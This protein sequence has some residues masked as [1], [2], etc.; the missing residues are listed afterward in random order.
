MITPKDELTA[1]LTLSKIEKIRPA[2]AKFLYQSVGNALDIFRL[3]KDLVNIVPGVSQ[4]LIEALDDSESLCEAEKE[5]CFIDKNAIRCLMPGDDDYPARLTECQDAPLILYTL[6]NLNLNAEHT[7]AVVGT[8]KA[9]VYGKR[10]AETFVRDL[11]QLCPGILVI[12]G[13]AYGIDIASHRAAIE[14]SLPTVGVLAHGLDRIYPASHRKDAGLMVNMGGL[15]TEFSSGTEPLKRNF[16]SRNRIVAGLAD[17][18]VVVES[19]MKGGSL[20]TAD[21]AE[22]YFR[23]CF[24]FPGA[25]GDVYSEGCNLLIRNNKA[26]LIQSAEDFV[27]D[28]GWNRPKV[29]IPVQ[30]QLFPDIDELSMKVLDAVGKVRSGVEIN[31]LVSECDIPIGQMLN[32]LLE[33]EMKGLVQSH[34]GCLYTKK[35]A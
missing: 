19:A 26:G 18:V 11:S 27:K 20:I 35:N 32:I 13:L 31:M 28:M 30:N 7:V 34:P 4:R 10:L 23:P 9:T 12:S 16:V 8:R 1:L 21:I 17:A 6:G 14:C 5:L 2:E 25:V 33:L 22:S 15:V 29:K 3:G 24:A